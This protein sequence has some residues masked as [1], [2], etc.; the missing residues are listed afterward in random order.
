LYNSYI[1]LLACTAIPLLDDEE[2]NRLNAETNVMNAKSAAKAA[3][4]VTKTTAKAT[5]RTVEMTGTAMNAAASGMNAMSRSSGS[6][7][8]AAPYV[9]G[10]AL[11]AA[12]KIKQLEFE[13]QMYQ[14]KYDEGMRSPNASDHKYANEIYSPM[15]EERK[16]S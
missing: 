2:L 9:S 12:D 16:K 8:G 15:V 5:I 3:W 10:L 4:W 6:K 14:E 1:K 7:A 11:S 13:I